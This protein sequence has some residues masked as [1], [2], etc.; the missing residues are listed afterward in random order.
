MNKQLL[1]LIISLVSFAAFAQQEYT[2]FTTAG[3]G[4]ATTFV[5]DYQ[6]IGINPA[7]LGYK[8]TYENKTIT[9]GLLEGGASV[10]SSALSKSQV[11]Q[12][13]IDFKGSNFTNA[14]KI[15]AASQFA[16]QPTSL[17]AGMT[18]FGASY[19]H[20]KA[21]GFAFTIRDDFRYFSQFN[22]QTAQIMFE[23]FGAP[24]FN[25]LTIN[26]SNGTTSN[27]PNSDTAYI[28]HQG[29]IASGSANNPASFSSI[30]GNSKMSM[31]YYRSYNLGYGK[32]FIIND[33]LSIN[34]GVDVKYLE[35]FGVL[36]VSEKNGSLNAYG[37]FSPAFGI[38]FGSAS[39]NNPSADTSKST[40]PKSAGHGFGADLGLNVTYKEKWR[41][42][43]AV[44]N[45][46]SITYHTNVYT[47][48]DVQVSSLSTPGING[49]NFLTQIP[50]LIGNGNNGLFQWK[51]DQ[52]IVVQLPTQLRIGLS[53]KFEDDRAH[54]G[55]DVVIPLN[56][57]PGNLV[58]PY[59][60]LGGDFK[61]VRWIRLSAGISHGGLYTSTVNI[62]L[63]ITF[64]MGENGTWEFGVASR[65]FV[66][67]FKDNGPAMSIAFGFLRFRI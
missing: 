59:Y 61:P 65:D 57:Q 7:N 55:I 36:G 40:L 16:N 42:G 33:L 51:G 6:S 63:G 43:I 44:T 54:V 47:L 48:K 5:T 8:P 35:G 21:G 11:E 18:W 10:Y 15:N 29:Q 39:L 45:I 12:T 31:L 66:A 49:Y 4:V 2:T 50:S 22:T 32:E 28:H 56:N 41:L 37:A 17:N 52:K 1:T 25:T 53:Q 14:Q 3:R 34:G 19:Q 23:G 30:F 9:I 26:N 38:N 20:E 27:I 13:Y 24:Y 46:G 64:I 62:P 58:N 60:A 67:Y